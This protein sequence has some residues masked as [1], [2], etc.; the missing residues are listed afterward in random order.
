MTDVPVFPS[1]VAV[2]MAEPVATPVT[3]PVVLS[4][5]ATAGVLLDHVMTRPL[6]ALLLASMSVGLSGKVAPTWTTFVAGK[7]LT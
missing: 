6:K 4:T 2:M 5:V 3:I 7:I 1:L